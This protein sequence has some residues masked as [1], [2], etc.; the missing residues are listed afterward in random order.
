MVEAVQ[1]YEQSVQFIFR[2]FPLPYHHNAFTAAQ[3]KHAVR[4]TV[5]QCHVHK[6]TAL[7]CSNQE[8]TLHVPCLDFIY[9]PP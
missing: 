8:G 5:I 2:L 9:I 6:M 3:V 4:R 1:I 7:A